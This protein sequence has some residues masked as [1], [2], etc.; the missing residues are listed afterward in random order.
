[1]GN[2]SFSDLTEVENA[3]KS[4]RD[5]YY[6]PPARGKLVGVIGNIGAGKTTLADYLRCSGYV[7]VSFAEPIK[8]VAMDMGFEKEEVDGT[9]AQKLSLNK[10][11][12]VS[13]REFMQK[14]GTDIC[15][16]TLPYTI[17]GM[18]NVWIRLAKHRVE[19][20]LNAGHNVVMPDV[21]FLDERD[22]IVETGGIIIRIDSKYSFDDGHKSESYVNEMKCDHVIVNERNDKFYSDIDSLGLTVNN[23]RRTADKVAMFMIVLA[24]TILIVQGGCGE[25]C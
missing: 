23:D 20:L 2:T 7:A 8:A 15:R 1:M 11:W 13:G 22:M 3:V 19:K 9:Q 25:Y 6:R 17:K 12:N 21:R 14:F 16:D 10:L 18:N 4:I 5:K 24:V